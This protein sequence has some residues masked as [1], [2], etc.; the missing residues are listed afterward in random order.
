MERN[1]VGESCET[2]LKRWGFNWFP[3]FRGTGARLT[4]IAGDWKEVHLR[5]PLNWRTRNY[6]GTIYG[7]SLYGAVD[8]VYMIMLIKLLGSRYTVWLKEASVAFLKPGRETLYARFRIADDH[9]EGIRRELEG[10]TNVLREY[11]I[12]IT[13]RSGTP[14]AVVREIIH[15][16]RK[17]ERRSS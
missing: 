10:R 9:L 1:V 2:R 5:I 3:A 14:H 7:G 12:P 11:E 17:N 8:P 4:Y 13:D 16:G 15:I 6:V